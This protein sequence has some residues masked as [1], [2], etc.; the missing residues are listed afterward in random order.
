MLTLGF[1]PGAQR[2]APMVTETVSPPCR[3]VG[4]L[5]GTFLLR[6][7]VERGEAG[8]GMDAH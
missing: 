7:L 2:A 8:R 5:L 4:G 1:L 6:I 3:L